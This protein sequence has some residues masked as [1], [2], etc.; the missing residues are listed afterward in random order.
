MDVEAL[1]QSLVK[2]RRYA[3]EERPL[4]NLL[5]L[6]VDAAGWTF[7]ETVKATLLVALK[8]Y[9]TL[10]N[11]SNQVS[12]GG[13]LQ[14][15][16][17]MIDVQIRFANMK[18]RGAVGEQQIEVYKTVFSMLK[19]APEVVHQAHYILG[20]MQK[21]VGDTLIFNGVHLRIERDVLTPDQQSGSLQQFLDGMAR[22]GFNA[23][24]LLYIASGVFD[25]HDHLIQNEVLDKVKPFCMHAIY[26]NKWKTT[27]DLH[28][29]NPEQVAL[30]DFLVLAKS[31]RF[32][33]ASSSSMSKFLMNYRQ[34]HYPY[35]AQK[36]ATPPSQH[37]IYT[38]VFFEDAFGEM[39]ETL[40]G[41]T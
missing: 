21:I 23:S 27:S 15:Q 20:K 19:F 24:T 29:L 30:I 41:Q 5:A 2:H 31:E 7:A 8:A 39:A 32:L 17:P 40:L 36:F 25:N 11:G 1:Q 22:D 12:T 9:S 33:G 28:K 18:T 6:E 13:D 14:L 10:R 38:Q 4:G 35:K 3:Y 16:V 37:D 34:F 26:H